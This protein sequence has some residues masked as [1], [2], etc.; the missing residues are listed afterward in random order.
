M[1]TQTSL[2]AAR[3]PIF[4]HFKPFTLADRDLIRDILWDYQAE[5]SELTFTNLFMWQSHYGYQWTMAHD[6]LLVVAAGADG[7]PWALPPVGPPNRA[8]L[9]REVLTWLR[10]ERG[11]AD[12]AIERADA[13]LAA[14]VADSPD[15]VVEPERQHFDY[16][17]RA[18]DLI[19]LAG[20]PYHA[21]R[22]HINSLA[23]TWRYEALGVD[24]LSACLN[25]SRKWCDDKRCELDL[26]LMGEWTAIATAL[27]NFESLGYQGGVMLLDGRVEAFACGE[28][29]NDTTAVI[30]LEKANPQK[31]N[32]YAVINQQVEFINREQD[33]GDPGLRQAKESYHPDHLV[34]KFRI[35]LA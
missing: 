35:R 11:V 23:G 2:F 20:K 12:P 6:R 22:N 32:L 25:V 18:A 1:G 3:L 17:Y 10:E 33:L 27:A 21:K 30:H 26:S 31:R 28:L 29:L 15:L 16:L 9:C 34:E 14:E 8:R 19:N 5:T 13:R 7:P 4:P 24:H